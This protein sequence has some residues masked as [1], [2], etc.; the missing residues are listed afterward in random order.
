MKL[1]VDV[2]EGKMLTQRGVFLK[3]YSNIICIV[4]LCLCIAE[5]DDR[6]NAVWWLL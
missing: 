3:T 4:Y 6:S 1:W 5:L 2:K